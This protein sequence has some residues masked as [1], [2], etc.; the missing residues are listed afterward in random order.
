MLSFVYLRARTLLSDINE[1]NAEWSLKTDM[2]KSGYLADHIEHNYPKGY[3]HETGI[4]QIY[5]WRTYRGKVLLSQE[6]L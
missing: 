3:G 6:V 2:L 5:E 1:F 4:E